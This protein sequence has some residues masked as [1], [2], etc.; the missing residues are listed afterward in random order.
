M[1]NHKSYEYDL[2]CF[3]TVSGIIVHAD[4]S[5][6]TDSAELANKGTADIEEKLLKNLSSWFDAVSVE[7]IQFD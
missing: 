6:T 2:V 1:E 3:S 5:I 7:K 4:G